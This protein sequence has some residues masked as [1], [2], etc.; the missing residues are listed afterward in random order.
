[1]LTKLVEWC[2]IWDV[3][4]LEDTQQRPSTKVHFETV[5]DDLG[6]F[7]LCNTLLRSTEVSLVSDISA[8]YKFLFEVRDGQL[9]MHFSVKLQTQSFLYYLR[10]EQVILAFQS[11]YYKVLYSYIIRTTDEIKNWH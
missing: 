4:T 10:N 3:F 5:L 11:A 9:C 2:L 7:R 1:M 6:L 8:D